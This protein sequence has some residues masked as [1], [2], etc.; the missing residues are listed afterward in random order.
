MTWFANHIYAANKPELLSAL[1]KHPILRKGLYLVDDISDYPWF[2]PEIRHGLPQGG[3]IVV[4]EICFPGIDSGAAE[5]HDQDAVFWESATTASIPIIPLQMLLSQNDNEPLGGDLVP[6]SALQSF[7]EI[8]NASGS[9]LI[10]YS[11][12]MWGGGTEYELAWSFGNYDRAT[13]YLDDETFLEVRLDTAPE[14]QAG[15][16]LKSVL[17][18][19]DMAIPTGYFALHARN[20]NWKRYRV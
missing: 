11:H 4:R 14:R 6:L 20:F 7:K 9:T 17:A 1:Q 8:S 5:W 13:R 15:A 10:Y 19:L 16:V 3:L 12:C 18:E 2:R